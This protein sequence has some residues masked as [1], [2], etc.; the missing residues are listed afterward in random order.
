VTGTT[1]PKEPTEAMVRAAQRRAEEIM[2]VPLTTLAAREIL[3][4]AMQSV[5]PA[6]SEDVVELPT[7][8]FNGKP[9]VT[10]AAAEAALAT[11]RENEVRAV[12]R[13][14]GERDP[15]QQ[16]TDYDNGWFAAVAYISAALTNTPT[17]VGDG[18]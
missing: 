4:A 8:F 16:L 14:A 5:T 11:P 18:Q 3:K 17:V 9:Y 1:P 2:P 13:R 12:I 7:V 6:P 15:N 10:L